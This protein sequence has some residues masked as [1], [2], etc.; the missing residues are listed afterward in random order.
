M[1]GEISV[2]YTFFF[3]GDFPVGYIIICAVSL[4]LGW[5]ASELFRH[6]SKKDDTNLVNDDRLKLNIRTFLLGILF[7]SNFIL[8][9]V[10]F[11]LRYF[12]GFH[13]LVIDYILIYLIAVFFISIIGGQYVLKR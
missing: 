9:L 11:V 3:I 7:F 8:L 4:F 12:L 5:L 13:H 1:K 10:L 6:K 2:S